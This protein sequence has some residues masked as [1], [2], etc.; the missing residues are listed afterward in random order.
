MSAYMQ[1]QKAVFDAMLQQ[2]QQLNAAPAAAARA[3]AF[4]PLPPPLSVDGDMEQNFEFFITNWEHYGK[5]VGIDKWP[6][7]DNER[8]VSLL[9]S[10]I[11]QAA[12]KKYSNFDLSVAEKADLTLAIAAIK[13]KVVIERNVNI[14]RL[15]FFEARQ[16]PEESIEDFVLRLKH[17]ARLA[18]LGN[19]AAELVTFKVITANRWPHLRQKMLTKTNI[20]EAEAVTFCRNQEIGEAR[21]ETT[22]VDV[23]KLK[24]SSKLPRCKFCGDRHQ[25]TKGTCPAWGKRCKGCGGK[26]HFERVCRGAT[27]KKK[28]KKKSVKVLKKENSNSELSSSETEDSES[29][30]ETSEEEAEIRKIYDNSGS[31]GRVLAELLLKFNGKWKAVNC[32]VDTG[33]DTNIVGLKQGE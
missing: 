22:K 26:N 18:K 15:D 3:P 13:A 30:N 19:L 2:M 28:S 10:V 29:E 20:T 16:H 6:N 32:E 5:S 11:G 23:H 33:A 27:E 7:D 9:M 21:A 31:G 17:L 14:D 1:S 8:K 25:F 12:L 4:V 24:S